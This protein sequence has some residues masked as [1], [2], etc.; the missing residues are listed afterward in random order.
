M[1]V[2]IKFSVDVDKE[3]KQLV[4]AY[5]KPTGLMFIV[6]FIFGMVKRFRRRPWYKYFDSFNDFKSYTENDPAKVAECNVA[7]SDSSSD[8][9]EIGDC[10]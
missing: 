10:N 5:S 8:N 2:P 4:D 3:T 9:T 1:L 7:Q 6:A